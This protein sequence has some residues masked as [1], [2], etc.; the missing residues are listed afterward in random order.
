MNHP[1]SLEPLLS[2]DI[3]FFFIIRIQHMHN[4]AP[5]YERES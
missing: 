5:I 3:N 4:A 2:S 1:L